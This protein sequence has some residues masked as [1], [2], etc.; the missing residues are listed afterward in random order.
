MNSGDRLANSF[1]FESY[2]VSVRVEC[3]DQTFLREAEEAARTALVGNF[4][5]IE[6]VE[7]PHSYRVAR[8]NGTYVLFKDG[9]AFRH[10]E[11]RKLFLKYFDSAVRIT[12]AEFAVGRVFLH[13]G[14]AGWKG[15]A[16]VV[17]GISFTGKTSLIA[18]LVKNGADYY[19]DEYAVFDEE[20][21]VYPFA[22][23]L[24]IRSR[25]E[26][27][28]VIEMS[29][30]TAEELGGKSGMDPLPVGCI[31]ITEFSEDAAWSPQVL[32][33]G[34]GVMEMLSQT[35]PIRYK[36]EFALEILKKVTANAIILKSV[37]PDAV[38]FAKIL[39]EFIDN[40]AF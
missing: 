2:G 12:V 38:K 13:A 40:K 21:M 20:G 18:E 6:H 25:P 36:P 5:I 7:T 30:P 37:R 35:I 17:P 14:V 39:L 22:R 26:G 19:S 23:K 15:R 8:E 29:Y 31:L 28:E 32:S 9:Q 10:G 33:Q 11:S 4:K 16:I 27:D 1:C 34:Q 3:D 24:A